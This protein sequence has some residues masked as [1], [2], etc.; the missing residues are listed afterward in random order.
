MSRL[1]AHENLTSS[2]MLLKI[3][4]S[5]PRFMWHQYYTTSNLGT[6]TN[7][8]HTTQNLLLHE[9]EIWYASLWWVFATWS[10]LTCWDSWKSKPSAFHMEIR[11]KS[12]KLTSRHWLPS[13]YLS[14]ILWE[15]KKKIMPIPC[16]MMEGATLK[17]N[18][19]D[20][21]LWYCGVSERGKTLPLSWPGS[22]FKLMAS[23]SINWYI[24]SG[25]RF[26]GSLLWEVT[27]A[28]WP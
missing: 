4:I 22:F 7:A 13:F 21:G 12:I 24:L 1:R 10:Q 25:L 9:E 11:N 3:W 19:H 2:Y 15:I 27:V 5:D 8:H 28:D 20:S 26:A 18:L 16:Q 17:E 6:S 14:L 23:F